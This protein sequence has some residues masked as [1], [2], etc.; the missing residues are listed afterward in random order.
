MTILALNKP[1][2]VHENSLEKPGESPSFFSLL[3]SVCP[4]MRIFEVCAYLPEIKDCEENKRRH[5]YDIGVSQ[6][7]LPPSIIF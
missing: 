5:M 7:R 6:A 2:A 1:A 4:E 3:V